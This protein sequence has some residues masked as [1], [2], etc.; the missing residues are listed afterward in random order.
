MN[1]RIVI[2]VSCSCIKGLVLSL[3]TRDD[4]GM[5]HKHSFPKASITK[6][7]ICDRQHNMHD[8]LTIRQTKR[9]QP[10]S[11]QRQLPLKMAV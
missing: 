1:A 2:R 6:V 10:N 11:R 4:Q 7:I 3:C 8:R 5:H 9:H